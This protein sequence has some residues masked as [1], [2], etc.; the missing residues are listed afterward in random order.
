MSAKELT[1]SSRVR[2][3]RDHV[4]SDLG[5]EAVIL[6][7]DRG[8]YYGVNEVG[9]RIWGLIQQTRSVD[10]VRDVIV[11]E[12]DVDPETCTADVLRLL[13]EMVKRGL[14]QV[15]PRSAR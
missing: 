14:I 11:A 9:S 6:E 1:G 12:Y 3:V 13:E 2:A 10:Q 4:S 8:I 15:D 7:L 5:R